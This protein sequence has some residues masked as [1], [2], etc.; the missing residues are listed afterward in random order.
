[1]GAQNPFVKKGV[2]D[3]K[4]TECPPFTFD[5]MMAKEFHHFIAFYALCLIIKR[6]FSSG[7]FQ[8]ERISVIVYIGHGYEQAWCQLIHR[9]HDA[10]KHRLKSFRWKVNQ[11]ENE[12]GRA[13]VLNFPHAHQLQKIIISQTHAYTTH[14][15]CV[16]SGVL[17]RNDEFVNHEYNP[18]IC[19]DLIFFL[20]LNE[21]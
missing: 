12:R 20:Y 13:T 10:W 19:A 6:D 5:W 21:Y 18:R 9:I 8:T 2:F 1:M 11:E 3:L 7:N 4:N 16:T 15:I 14:Q 17:Y